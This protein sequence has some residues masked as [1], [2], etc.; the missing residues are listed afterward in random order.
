MTPWSY[1]V[2][3]L[4]VTWIDRLSRLT[5]H[6]QTFSLEVPYLKD[7]VYNN[8]LQTIEDLKEEIQHNLVDIFQQL[9][10]QFI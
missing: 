7:K 9:R 5:W 8:K 3:N 1:C 6:R 2:Q 4:T 10:Q